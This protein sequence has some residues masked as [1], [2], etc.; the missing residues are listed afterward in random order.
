MIYFNASAKTHD[1]GRGGGGANKNF[2]VTHFSETAQMTFGTA[3]NGGT[4]SLK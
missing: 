1:R 4:A 3:Q 2:S